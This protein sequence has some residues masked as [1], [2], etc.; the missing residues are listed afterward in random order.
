LAAKKIRFRGASIRHLDMRMGE[1]AAFVRAHI[2]CDITPELAE[3]FAWEIYHG[4]EVNHRLIS[5]LEGT[6]KLTG[7]VSL[8]SIT[9]K[10]NGFSADDTLNAV[11]TTAED[12]QL[13]RKK[14]ADGES[15]DTS[16]RFVL[17]SQAWEYFTGFFGIK[18]QNDG[19]LT[20][21]PQPENLKL[22]P[23]LGEQTED[24]GDD[25]EEEDQAQQQRPQRPKASLRRVQ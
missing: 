7:E 18:G 22:Q 25:P 24:A 13:S 21:Q 17:V 2:Q 14:S 5:G 10:P 6:T 16:L 23:E 11:A 20:L 12:F 9:F 15:F 1:G 4:D 19:V 8:E 3:R